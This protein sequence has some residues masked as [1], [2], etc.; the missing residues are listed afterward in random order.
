M[1]H[2]KCK[3]VAIRGMEL[4]DLVLL[5]SWRNNDQL[6][7]YFRE[8]REL[9]ITQLDNWYKDMTASDKFEFFIIESTRKKEAIGVAGITYIDWVNSHGDVHFYIGE[10]SKWIDE[11]YSPKA[12]AMILEY[13]FNTLNL[14]KLWAE[15][16]SIDK[17]KLEF[18]KK[19]GFSIDA[20]LRDH[21]YN[22]GKYHNSHI[23]SLLK[24]EYE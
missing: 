19:T 10:S 2:S 16:Y 5:Q 4:S 18:F 13:G 15:V 22:K 20:T 24:N 23:L 7:R 21:Y 12:F 3:E 9:S 6:R 17:L 8:Y 11:N 1:I 14:N